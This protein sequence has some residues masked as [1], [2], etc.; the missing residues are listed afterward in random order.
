MHSFFRVGKVVLSR[1]VAEIPDRLGSSAEQ[2]QARLEKLC[3][4]RLLV[5]FRFLAAARRRLREIAQVLGSRRVPVRHADR[6]CAARFSTG[7]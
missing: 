5:W 3:Q 7:P 6:L 1:E 2:W 4:Q